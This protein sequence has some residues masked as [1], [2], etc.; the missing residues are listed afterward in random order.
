MAPTPGN[1]QLA[2]LADQASRDLGSGPVVAGDPG[3]R[4]GGDV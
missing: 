1:L 3:A 4:G 2:D